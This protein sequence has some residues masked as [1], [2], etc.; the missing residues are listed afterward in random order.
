[1]VRLKATVNG[2]MAGFIASDLRRG[3][4]LAWIVTL[5][6]LPEFRRMGIARGLLRACEKRLS[7]KTIRLS[8]RRT[9]QPAIDL[10]ISEGYTQ[11]DV[12]GSY[13]ADGED[14]LILQKKINL[15][16]E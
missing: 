1:V 10:Y 6:T 15:P 12:W 14:A 9:N 8:V 13:Y 2:R 5:G 11:V 4:E 3:E 7:V 16:L